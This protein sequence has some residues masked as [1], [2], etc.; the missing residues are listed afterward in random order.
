MPRKVEESQWT[1][2]SW[3]FQGAHRKFKELKGTPG[4]SGERQ[5]TP[6]NSGEI[7]GTLRNFKE[8]QG[9]LRNSKEL[10]ETPRNSKEL[11]GTLETLWKSPE[12]C[13]TLWHLLGTPW[14]SLSKKFPLNN[15]SNWVKVCNQHWRFC[16]SLKCTKTMSEAAASKKHQNPHHRLFYATQKKIIREI[17]TIFIYPILAFMHYWSISRLHLDTLI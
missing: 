17:R 10:Q 5:R 13:G 3:E 4:N 15:I 8:L 16:I 9:T 7:W 14:N 12:L 2:N 11:L 1:G 6:G